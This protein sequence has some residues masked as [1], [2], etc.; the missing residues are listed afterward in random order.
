MNI[1]GVK[2]EIEKDI[3]IIEKGEDTPIGKFIRKAGRIKVKTP[4][5]TRE[6]KR[7]GVPGS[8]LAKEAE[9]LKASRMEKPKAV[10]KKKV[11]KKTVVKKTVAKRGRPRKKK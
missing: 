9:K 1:S 2:I 4:F 7:I 6:I 11:A 8:E 3:A 5:G 10:V